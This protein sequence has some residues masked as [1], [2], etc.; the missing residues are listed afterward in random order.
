[1]SPFCYLALILLFIYFLLSIFGKTFLGS[2]VEI[3]GLQEIV[4]VCA[5]CA[6]CNGVFSTFCV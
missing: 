1:M 2:C 3:L 6:R 4:G 5:F